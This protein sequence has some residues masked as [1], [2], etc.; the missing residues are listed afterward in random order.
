MN[1]VINRL[2]NATALKQKR[3]D[4]DLAAEPV[5]VSRIGPETDEYKCQRVS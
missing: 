3:V 4:E 5:I 2:K 1:R